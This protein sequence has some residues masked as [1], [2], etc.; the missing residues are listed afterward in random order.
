MSPARLK[1]I[2]SD[3]AASTLRRPVQVCLTMPFHP[4]M[5]IGDEPQSYPSYRDIALGRIADT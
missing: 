4:M 2:C 1:P 5:L 3:N